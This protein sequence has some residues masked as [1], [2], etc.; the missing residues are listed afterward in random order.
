MA[1]RLSLKV[2][3]RKVFGKKL[4]QLRKQ[5]ILP[6]NVYGKALKST[7]V[8]VPYKEFEAVFKETGESGLV[9]LKLDSETRPVLIKNVA[10]ESVTHLP[11][12]ADFYQVNLAEKVK[13]MVPL[14]IVGEPKA[15]TEKI[16][17]L[18]QPLSEVEVEALPTDLPENIEVNVENLAAVGDQITVDQLKKPSGVEILTDPSQV[19][20]KIDELVS[21]EAQEQAAADAAAAEASK[22]EEGAEGEAGAEKAEAGEN[23]EE[24]STKPEENAKE[25]PEQKTQS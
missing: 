23:K 15:V 5:G 7:A 3:K 9:D 12:H 16:G 24:G 6:G 8:E 19:V 11:L 14:V 4:K 18:L 13:T 25:A 2:T 20:V 10:Y 1:Q 21:K 22:A 17:L